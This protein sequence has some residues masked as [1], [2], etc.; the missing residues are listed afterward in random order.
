MLKH[1]N[2]NTHAIGNS[3]PAGNS[4]PE[5]ISLKEY[6]NDRIIG[7]EKSIDTRF[8]SVTTNIGAALAAADKATGK[9][10][11]A[12]EKRFDAVNEFRSTLSDQQRT[13][14]PR[15]EFEVLHKSL[16]DT[17]SVLQKTLN[18]KIDALNLTTI[19]RQSRDTGQRE[20]WGQIALIAGIISTLVVLLSRFIR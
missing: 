1:N 20:G 16:V 12:S 7:L 4:S 8:E 11:G 19:S 9:A 6:I 14:M 2:M 13:L 15:A 10:E 18:D 17:V 3:N 5:G